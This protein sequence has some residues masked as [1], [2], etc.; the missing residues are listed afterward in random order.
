MLL[1]HPSEAH[2]L[3][4]EGL[5]LD[6]STRMNSLLWNVCETS[7]EYILENQFYLNAA[8]GSNEIFDQTLI[9]WIVPPPLKQADRLPA[10]HHPATKQVAWPTWVLGRKSSSGTS[11]F[12]LPLSGPPP[13]FL[14]GFPFMCF[15][16]LPY[17]TCKSSPCCL[18]LYPAPSPCCSWPSLH[19]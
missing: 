10:F 7:V 12:F 2:L 13:L 4:N 3:L 19:G 5:I 8:I 15:P 9:S 14:L 17:S 11:V 16:P 18:S 6:H 1:G